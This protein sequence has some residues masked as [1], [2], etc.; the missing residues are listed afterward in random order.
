[1]EQKNK[2]ALDRAKLYIPLHKRKDGTPLNEAATAKIEK[3][4]DLMRSQPSSSEG[5]VSGRICWS[6]NDIY[7]QVMDEERTRDKEAIIELK[8]QVKNQGDRWL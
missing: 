6:P 7:S 4:E 1:M 5:N 8:E 2:I 3:L